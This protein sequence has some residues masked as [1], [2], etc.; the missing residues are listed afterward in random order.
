MSFSI[1]SNTK[2]LPFDSHKSSVFTCTTQDGYNLDCS[3]RTWAKTFFPKI[4]GTSASRP[5]WPPLS[6]QIPPCHG[7]L[8][9]CY[10]DLLLSFWPFD[11]HCLTLVPVGFWFLSAD[12]FLTHTLHLGSWYA[13]DSWLLIWLLSHIGFSNSQPLPVK[14]RF[15]LSFSL[16]SYPG[17]GMS[18]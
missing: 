12:L 13:S 17:P 6:L 15:A 16:A 8:F 14:L 4:T 9:V 2:P 7:H 18:H 5:S 1:I 3:P 11:L 10:H